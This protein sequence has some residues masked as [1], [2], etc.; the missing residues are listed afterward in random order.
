MPW[1]KRLLRRYAME[2][3]NNRPD[4]SK[5]FHLNFHILLIAAIVIIAVVSI[6]KLVIW[7]I[8]TKSDYD[9]DNLAEGFDVEVLDTIIP[10]SKT[11][12]EG[13]EDDGV[14]T[15]L[16]LGNSMLADGEGNGAFAA[17]LSAKTE[18][19]VYSAGFPFSR[20]GTRN[21]TYS[22]DYLRD[23]FNLPYV[24][25]SICTQDFSK[26]EYA[27]TFEDDSRFAD[28]VNTL[29]SLDYSKLDTIV[30]MYDAT[31]YTEG[32]AVENPGD[33]HELTTYT[34]ALRTAIENIQTAYPYIRIII[35]SHTFAHSLDADGNFMS[36]DTT[37]LGN[38]AL[39]HYL[40]KEVDVA[41]E[42][43]VSVIDN[44][45][46]TINEDNYQDYMTDYLHYNDKGREALANRLAEVI[47]TGRTSAK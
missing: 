6:V 27:A 42:M 35:M 16:C 47:N 11:K 12:L 38:G 1:N 2:E 7:N 32:T 29:K 24:A 41:I 15:I 45:Y 28:S 18:A 36:G 34:G 33:P 9:P 26:M 30:I 46:G 43:G 8:G 19:R 25:Q 20:I 14:N 10:L 21:L 5:T 17:Q 37:D 23:A 4:E 13:H 22:G 39:P 44:Y 31:D 40:V 3:E